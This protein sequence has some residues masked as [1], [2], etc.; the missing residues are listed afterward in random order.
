MRI[1]VDAM[2]GDNA[3]AQVLEGA[4]QA[5]AEY[6]IEASVVGSPAVVQPLLD[7]HPHLR[8]CPPTQVIAM[9]E[10]PTPAVRANPISPTPGAPGLCKGGRVLG[11]TPPGDHGP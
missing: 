8:L 6:G 4:S 11:W 1:A 5:V 9:D 2:G 3:P 7:Q 10:H